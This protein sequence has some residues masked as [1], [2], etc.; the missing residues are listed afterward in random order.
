[1]YPYV[2][3]SYLVPWRSEEG[4]KHPGPGVVDGCEPPC[5]CWGKNLSSLQGLQGVWVHMETI[6]QPWLSFLRSRLGCLFVCFQV[7]D[8]VCVCVRACVY[9]VC[10][11]V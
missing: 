6:G 2:P 8:C 7:C 1:M 9:A 4:V 5:Q 11:C 3:C 10:A